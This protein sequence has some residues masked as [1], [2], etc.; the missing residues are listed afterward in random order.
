MESAPSLCPGGSVG[1][2]GWLL[3]RLSAALTAVPLPGGDLPDHG[4]TAPYPEPCSRYPT[5]QAS[6]CDASVFHLAGSLQQ[7]AGNLQ[8]V[9]SSLMCDA[10]H[11][12]A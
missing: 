11:E 2:A 7:S 10:K 5:L 4:S 3:C 6:A 9:F 12:S 1:A 8:G